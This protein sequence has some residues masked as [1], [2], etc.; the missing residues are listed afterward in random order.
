VVT[1]DTITV[2]AVVPPIFEMTVPFNTDTFTSNLSPSAKTL[3]GGV[4]PTIKTNA[5]GGWIMWAKDSNQALTSAGSG[6]SIPSVGWNSNATT[7][8]TNGT[9]QYAL[10]V[11]KFVVG[12]AFTPICT[13]A[14]DSEYDSAGGGDGGALFA[15]YEEIGT[16][17]GGSSNGDGMTLK[18]VSTISVVTPAATDYTDV[19]TVVGAG[20]F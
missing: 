10:S 5:K 12:G 19:I 7:T 1:D 17:P 3:T 15:N 6:G 8:L 14:V 11:V 9:P 13:P 18:E 16:C 2:S 20:L 4:T